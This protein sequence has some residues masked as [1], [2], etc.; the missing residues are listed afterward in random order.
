[1]PGPQDKTGT[2]SVKAERGG[3]LQLGWV[4]D[5]GVFSRPQ[6]RV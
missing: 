6:G 2:L 1:M 4:K 3:E 5:L